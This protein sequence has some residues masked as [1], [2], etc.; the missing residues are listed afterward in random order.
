MLMKTLITCLL[1]LSLPVLALD[2]LPLD[3]LQPGNWAVER[4]ITKLSEADAPVSTR[5]TTYCASP[6]KEIK[7]LLTMANLLCKTQIKTVADNQFDITATCKLPGGLAGSNHSTLTITDSANYKLETYTKG[8][9]F[10]G[11]PIERREVISAKR[12]GECE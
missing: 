1:A 8:T 6:K 2:E 7:K 9:K 12:L 10:G 5:Q 4:V 11:V 3:Q